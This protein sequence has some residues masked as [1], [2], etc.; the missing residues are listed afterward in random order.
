MDN[1]EARPQQMAVDFGTSNTIV[2]FWDAGKKD[3]IL[4]PVKDV[5]RPFFYR[6]NGRRYEVPCIPSMISYQDRNISFIG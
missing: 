4:H 5:T 3:V 2:A 1:G 6:H